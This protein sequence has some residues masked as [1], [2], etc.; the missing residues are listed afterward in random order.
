MPAETVTS[1]HGNRN[2]KTCIAVA[3]RAWEMW[4][5]SVWNRSS[6]CSAFGMPNTSSLKRLISTTPVIRL[7]RSTTGNARNLCSTKNSQASSTV[8]VSGI[9]ITRRIITSASFSPGC[10]RS[11]LRVC[12]TPVSFD[13]ASTT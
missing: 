11:R 8:A 1:S 10:A 2:R 6:R 3:C 13:S 4:K 12:S 5:P 9:A 7:S